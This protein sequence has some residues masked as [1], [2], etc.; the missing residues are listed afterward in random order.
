MKQGIYFYTK[1]AKKYLK[2]A[3][4]NLILWNNVNE[5]LKDKDISETVKKALN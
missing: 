2:W 1:P 3:K 4:N 5:A